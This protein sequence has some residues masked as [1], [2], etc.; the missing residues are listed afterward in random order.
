MTY[1]FNP[2][3]ADSLPELKRQLSAMKNVVNSQAR[4]IQVLSNNV[5]VIT[6][7]LSSASVEALNSER[8]MNATLTQ[9]LEDANNLNRHLQEKLSV[10][11]FIA[12]DSEGVVGWHKNGIV[13]TWD[14]LLSEML[15]EFHGVDI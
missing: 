10:F 5:D 1:N 6:K 3:P 12:S 9:E 4:T 2:K 13:A 11:E 14:E 15:E 8:E 7:Q